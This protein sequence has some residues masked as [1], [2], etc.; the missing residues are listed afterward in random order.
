MKLRKNLTIINK[1]AKIWLIFLLAFIVVCSFAGCKCSD[2]ISETFSSSTVSTKEVSS[3]VESD[4][5]TNNSSD[6]A[7]DSDVCSTG[8]KSGSSDSSESDEGPES[9]EQKKLEELKKELV[10][11]VSSEHSDVELSFAVKNLDTGAY[12]VYNNK[13]M[14][15]ASVIKL[16]ILETVYKA[17]ENGEYVL[18]EKRKKDLEIMITE[19]SNKASNSFID[20]FGGEN[21]N[22][23][24]EVTNGINMC[25]NS[26]GYQF[27]EL[28]RKMN[29]V[30]PPG[31]PT[32]YENYTCVEDVCKFL[33]GIYSKTLLKEPHNTEALELLKA[34]TRRKKIP[35]KII[36]KYS[37]VIVANK[38]GE[39]AEVENDVALI[40]SEDF[41]LIFAVMINNIPKLSDGNA[42][43]PLKERVQETISDMALRLVDFYKEN[44]F[45]K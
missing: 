32:G 1:N 21:E 42:D 26:S 6:K 31:G 28:N 13:K 2:M 4:G 23:K 11:I 18:D 40:M 16:F 39:I 22:R 41:H 37:D 30:T 5:E 3:V 12:V 7:A 15:S 8:V 19:S 45:R 38:T 29:D 20:D 17:V 36:E 25:I 24:V 33:E 14:N 34:Q 44:D 35:C 43:Y 27:T 9:F 10:E